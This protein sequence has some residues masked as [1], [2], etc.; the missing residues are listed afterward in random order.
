MYFFYLATMRTVTPATPTRTD[1]TVISDLICQ[2]G[3]DPPSPSGDNNSSPTSLSSD[4]LL[5]L[6]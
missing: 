4:Q 2:L 1:D 3:E 6:P 5:A